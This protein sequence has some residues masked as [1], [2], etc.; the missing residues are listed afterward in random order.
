MKTVEEMNELI[1]KI[2]H[3]DCL[4]FMKQVPDGYFDLTVTSPP[5]NMRLRVRNGEYTE[6]EKGESFSRKYKHFDDALNIEDF[7]NFHLESIKEMMRIS[8][9]VLYNFQ[10]VTGSKEAFFKIIGEMAEH[11]KDIVIWDKGNGQPSMHENV[12]NA[13]HEFILVIEGDKKKG[14]S[15]TNSFFE[16]GRLSNIWRVRRGKKEVETHSAV[17]PLVLSK[18]AIQSFA[19][20]KAKVFDPF[21]GSGTTAIACKSLGLEWCGCELEAD[22]VAIANKRLEAVQGSLF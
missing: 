22:Y 1:G 12:L 6:R 10:I 2:H 9:I 13:T 16:R 11:I 21:M 5:Y 14:R 3:I 18:L 7:Y 8:N 20:I 19:P 17:M 4:E 15:V